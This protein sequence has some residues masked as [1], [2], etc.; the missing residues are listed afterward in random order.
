M[1][2]VYSSNRFGARHSGGWMN[3]PN[4]NDAR[5]S[6]QDAAGSALGKLPHDTLYQAR[7]D[8][9][10]RERRQPE[11]RLRGYSVERVSKKL[12]K[13]M[14]KFKVGQVWILDDPAFI[15]PSGYVRVVRMPPVLIVEGPYR[16]PNDVFV[17][18]VPLDVVLGSIQWKETS[19]DEI[20]LT[21]GIFRRHVVSLR[22]ERPVS[23]SMFEDII[24]G[25]LSEKVFSEVF[26]ARE[27]LACGEAVC[28]PL[29]E[30]HEEF[31]RSMRKR[32]EC[33]SHHVDWLRW[34]LEE[35]IRIGGD[36]KKYVPY[37]QLCDGSGGWVT[38]HDVAEIIDAMRLG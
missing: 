9:V 25:E 28:S 13:A 27:K 35:F 24:Q 19:E 8:R 34:A 30:M 16:T 21:E 15:L 2:T 4:H 26:K 33:A 37:S 29:S 32:F 18:A 36:I 3:T 10:Q 22:E 14:G 12:D 1:Q 31:R 20:R 11:N 17:R 6:G 5:Q 23:H 38:D 7:M